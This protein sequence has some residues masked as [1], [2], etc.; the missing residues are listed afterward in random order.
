MSTCG[1]RGGE[2]EIIPGQEA[3]H[4]IA[5]IEVM[6]R[7]A[8]AI[9]AEQ[10]QAQSPKKQK[11][12][13]SQRRRKMGGSGLESAVVPFGLLA[14]QQWFG[15]RNRNK[16]SNNNTKNKSMKNKSIKNKSKKNRK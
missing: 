16:L 6:R 7:H 11:K 14:V 10:A 9:A 4:R 3:R 15:T 2:P 12:N 8:A 1:Q 5:Q 13:K